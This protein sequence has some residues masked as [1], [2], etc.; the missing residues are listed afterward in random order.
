[1][2]ERRSRMPAVLLLHFGEPPTPDSSAVIDFLER[3]FSA[4]ATLEVDRDPARMRQRSRE[5]AK[6][7]APGLL[8]DYEQIGGSPL[9]AQAEAQA[10]G[11][12]RALRAR[13][14]DAVVS[15]GMQFTPPFIEEAVEDLMETKPSEIVAIPVYPLCG[16][17]TTVAALKTVDQALD[18]VREKSATASCH[19]STSVR[20][21]TGWHRHS[22]YMELRADAVRNAAS[23]IG[24]DLHDPATRMV[25]SA[26]GTPLHYVARGSRYVEYV[27]EWCSALADTLGLDQWNLG[28]QNHSN[29]PVEWTQPSI[30]DTLR[31]I[32]KGTEDGADPPDRVLLDP[33]SFMHEQSETLREIDHDL[34]KVAHAAGLD[35]HRVPI[36]HDDVRFA[37]VL[38]DLTLAALGDTEVK[39]PPA[40]SCRCYPSADV[41]FNGS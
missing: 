14:L 36:P 20:R 21:V 1:M 19:L 38:A 34:K 25:F 23:A 24:W 28:Y 33:V 4:N 13:S 12:R 9:N 5:L 26:H 6:K 18:R 31:S 11:L 40:T 3:I 30:E 22:G 7:R 32:A 10:G 29:R 27:E 16:P 39:V 35:F 41:C 8:H 37:E 15:S 17:S 2:D